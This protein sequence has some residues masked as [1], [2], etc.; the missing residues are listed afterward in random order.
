MKKM[1]EQTGD[2]LKT[3]VKDGGA[4]I[5]AGKKCKITIAKTDLM[6]MKTTSKIWSYKNFEMKVESNT[7]GNIIKSVVNKFEENVKIDPK[8]ITVPSDVLLNVV[9]SPF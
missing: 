6:E 7:S 1:S 2:A 8:N 4:G 3:D 5:V 9:E